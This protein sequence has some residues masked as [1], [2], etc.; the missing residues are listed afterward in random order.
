LDTESSARRTG[1]ESSSA[2]MESSPPPVKSS[3]A[4]RRGLEAPS[5]RRWGQ[6][7]SSAAVESS[8]GLRNHHQRVGG[9]CNRPRRR[10]RGLESSPP[11]ADEHAIFCPKLSVAIIC[12][13]VVSCQFLFTHR[14]LF[15]PSEHPSAPIR[16]SKCNPSATQRDE[17]SVSWPI[18]IQLS[19]VCLSSR[20]VL[21]TDRAF[22]CRTRP[23]IG[24]GLRLVV[25]FVALP[26]NLDETS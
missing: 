17:A 25:A 7:L 18:S 1:K 9:A 8:S 15:V 10:W 13:T 16:T 20:M 12:A 24:T 19:T 4:R 5:A 21:L 11:P 23:S 6:E 2:P 26:A 14:L 22:L 3:S